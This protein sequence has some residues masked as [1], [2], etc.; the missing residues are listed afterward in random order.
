MS[1]ALIYRTTEKIDVYIVKTNPKNPR[2]NG[3]RSNPSK[4]VLTFRP[5]PGDEIEFVLQ[6]TMEVWKRISGLNCS[7]ILVVAYAI[8]QH[9]ERASSRHGYVK[10]Q[11]SSSPS[12]ECSL[13]EDTWEDSADHPILGELIAEGFNP[14]ED[15]W[16]P[17]EW[18]YSPVEIKT[19][20]CEGHLFS[21]TYFRLTEK[22]GI[23]LI[24]E[25]EYYETKAI[26]V[27]LNAEMERQFLSAS[28]NEH[29]GF[30]EEIDDAEEEFTFEED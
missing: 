17:C 30:S 2:H 5:N 23:Q 25:K 28:A 16:N 21:R 7:S 20:S 13:G 3:L 18:L 22:D 4:Y 27:D 12:H 29:S 14:W 9:S 1:L 10:I 24:S 8:R 26:A 19:T 11:I 6:G 15:P